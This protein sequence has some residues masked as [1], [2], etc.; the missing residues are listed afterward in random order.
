MPFC[1]A[2]SFTGMFCAAR[3]HGV[4]NTDTLHHTL[5]HTAYSSGCMYVLHCM[6]SAL[7]SG[8]E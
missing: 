7:R 2:E 6:L 8:C 4:P 5:L 1:T 3:C